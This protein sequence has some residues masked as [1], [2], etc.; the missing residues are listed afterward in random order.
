MLVD[1]IVHK[2]TI[3]YE[4]IVIFEMVD[5]LRKAISCIIQQKEMA[6]AFI[7]EILASE[8]PEL[9]LCAGV[10]DEKGFVSLLN[11]EIGR[12]TEES[13]NGD[14][15]IPLYHEALFVDCVIKKRID[16]LYSAVENSLEKKII[17]YKSKRITNKNPEY[18]ITYN[19]LQRLHYV[20]G[21]L[22]NVDENSRA[23]FD[24]V[25]LTESITSFDRYC[26]ALKAWKFWIQDNNCRE[27]LFASCYNYVF[28][29]YSIICVYEHCNENG[30]SENE[31]TI[32]SDDYNWICDKVTQDY[33]A[34]WNETQQNE[35]FGLLFTVGNAIGHN[36][37]KL[38]EDVSSKLGLKI[39]EEQL[40]VSALSL[41]AEKNVLE[42]LP[43]PERC[44]MTEDGR[45]VESL[46]AF[47]CRPL[48]EKAKLFGRSKG[49][50]E[51]GKN[52]EGA[53]LLKTV[54]RCCELLQQSA[55]YLMSM[56][57][58]E[59]MDEIGDK[60]EVITRPEDHISI[61]FRECYNMAYNEFFDISISDQSKRSTTGH[62]ISSSK[63]M[64]PAE[65]D[66]VY[67]SDGKCCV[68]FEAFIL[69]KKSG[70]AVYEDHMNKLMKNDI[71]YHSPRFMIVYFFDDWEKTKSRW[72]KYKEYIMKY[73]NSVNE[74]GTANPMDVGKSETL[75]ESP[76]YVAEFSDR[77]A[78]MDLV[79]QIVEVDEH[80][81]EL[82]HILVDLH[83][84]K[85]KQY[86]SK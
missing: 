50:E 36:V 7:N 8:I 63:V 34:F 54:L 41:N 32:I 46:Q 79:R 51:N 29:L 68:L 33:L 48:K 64:S 60:E 12:R 2:H 31:K 25:F 27:Y 38:V 30:I 21:R 19:L 85:E 40:F 62:K 58:I 16:V 43:Q 71:S 23:F 86:C 72:N 9:V 17:Y 47:Y 73:S 84:S 61:L 15:M 24:A 14:T 57:D 80:K 52:W 67:Y 39:S 69:G 45:I 44:D 56:E 74:H 66:M 81:I 59:K 53:F 10:I 28:T 26:N 5:I 11:D 13:N 75:K 20:Q 55:P 18:R 77:L 76:C 78:G 65:A 6:D 4:R 22:D 37:V 3:T 1:S 82:F 70:E 49:I 42:V 83:F 35:F